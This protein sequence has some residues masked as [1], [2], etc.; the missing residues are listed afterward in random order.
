MSWI[1]HLTF[2][3]TIASDPKFPPIWPEYKSIFQRRI[4]IN[5]QASPGKYHRRILT[6]IAVCLR[7]IDH[8]LHLEREQREAGSR[9]PYSTRNQTT[10][11]TVTSSSSSSSVDLVSLISTSTHD[12][13]Q[14]TD[15]NTISMDTNRNVTI[16][17]LGLTAAHIGDDDTTGDPQP[18]RFAIT[19][20]T[21]TRFP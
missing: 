9:Q 12:S 16:G 18:D 17:T 7:L 15:D 4:G 19:T 11:A 21:L 5:G 20:S 10:S 13:L 6:I 8:D 2:Y 3:A 1:Y 14:D